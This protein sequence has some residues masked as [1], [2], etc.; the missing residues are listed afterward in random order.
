MKHVRGSSSALRRSRD[1]EIRGEIAFGTA[2]VSVQVN[3]TLSLD[4][5]RQASS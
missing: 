5:P 4:P 1:C 2:V 3:V